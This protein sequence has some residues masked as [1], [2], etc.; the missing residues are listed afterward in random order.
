MDTNGNKGLRNVKISCKCSVS[1]RMS[2]RAI[3]FELDL[4]F[5]TISQKGIKKKNWVRYLWLETISYVRGGKYPLI[6]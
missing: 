2:D 1:V 6:L 3:A 5:T 4:L